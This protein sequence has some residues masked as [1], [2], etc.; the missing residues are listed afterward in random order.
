MQKKKLKSLLPVLKERNR[1]I[2][3][4][5]FSKSRINDFKAITGE[6]KR[7]ITNFVG[8]LGLSKAGLYTLNY[9]ETKQIGIIKVAHTEVDNIKASLAMIKEV[10]G[11]KALFQTISVSGLLNKIEKR[12]GG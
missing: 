5:I 11:E 10:N 6:I 3:F 9:D 2:A 8:L 4:K 7:S 1:Y 12:I